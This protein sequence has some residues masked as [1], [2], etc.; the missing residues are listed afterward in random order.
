MTSNISLQTLPSMAKVSL[1]ID[2]RKV[3][4]A[5][6][7]DT[8]NIRESSD[9]KPSSLFFLLQKLSDKLRKLVFR[10]V[11][12]LHDG[13]MVFLQTQEGRPAT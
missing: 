9:F 7:V 6:A 10:V 1:A 4:L 13:E 12:L 11:K 8:I 5:V 3:C 2:R